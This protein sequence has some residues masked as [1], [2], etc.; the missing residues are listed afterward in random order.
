[1][2]DIKRRLDI[3]KKLQENID[4]T[5]ELSK[6]IISISERDNRELDKDM[7]IDHLAFLEK[8]RKELEK[9]ARI[10]EEKLLS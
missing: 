9:E 5:F 8:W 4:E 7:I 1:M 6:E 3:N 2:L 10:L